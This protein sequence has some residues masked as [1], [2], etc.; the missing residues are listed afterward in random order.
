MNHPHE[1]LADLMDGTLDE[2]D[3]AGVQA[4][5]DV[6]ASC[7]EDI[8]HAT[9]GQQAARSLPQ[10]TAPTD[11]HQRITAEAGGRG[12]GTPGWY[13]WAGVAAAAAVVVAVAIALPSVGD[14]AGDSRTTEDAQRP[15]GA[16]TGSQESIP[17]RQVE[18]QDVNYDP[19]GLERLARAVRTSAAQTAEAAPNAA[20]ADP[21]EAARCVSQ[22]FDEQPA[23]RLARLIQARFEGRAAYI[24]VYLEDPGADEPPDTAVV[25]VASKDDCTILSFASA[26]I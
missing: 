2:G 7:R 8:A 10:A 26:R 16:G 23:G 18:V 5:L 25:W 3:L 11:L 14:G 13:R 17:G 19:K 22:A 12:R 24:A 21:I 15:M 6:C 4:H 20:L 9:A 1:L